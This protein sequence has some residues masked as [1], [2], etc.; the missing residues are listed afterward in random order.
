M[1]HKKYFYPFIALFVIITVTFTSGWTVSCSSSDFPTVK[2]SHHHQ[3]Q[4]HHRHSEHSPWDEVNMAALVRRVV[5]LRLCVIGCTDGHMCETQPSLSL[6][7][8]FKKKKI[9]N[10]V[11]K[12]LSHAKLLLNSLNGLAFI[13]LANSW[14]CD[15]SPSYLYLSP[16]L[17]SHLMLSV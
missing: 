10:L 13:T 3:Q 6:F 9:S 11:I 4:R 12:I 2:K 7:N 14:L 15:Y 17:T 8:T 16:K 1:E 5:S